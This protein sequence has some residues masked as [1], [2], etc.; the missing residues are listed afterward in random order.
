MSQHPQKFIASGVV[1]FGLVSTNTAHYFCSK[2][3]LSCGCLFV[4][5]GFTQLDN[6]RGW[7]D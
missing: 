2:A 7:K 3:F 1:M 6:S 4:F 5:C